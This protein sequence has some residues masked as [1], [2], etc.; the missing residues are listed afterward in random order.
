MVRNIKAGLAL[1]AVSCAVALSACNP[2]ANTQSGPATNGGTGGG[3][4]FSKTLS[5]TLK[6]SGFNPSDEVGKARGD[7]ATTQVAP[8]TVSMDTTNFD[9]Q[10]FAAQAAS[11]N[12]P[13]LIQ[14][15]R[16]TVDT[17]ADKGLIIPLDQCFSTWG[18]SP[19]E[20]YYP[21]AIKDVTYN[22]H[23]YGVP[24]FFQAS[25]IIGNKSVM[26]PAGVT[27]AD[28]DTSKP[29]QLIQVAKKMTKQ[30]GGKP[31]QLGFSPD[32]PGSSA[33][34]LA[35]FGGKPND[36]NGKPTLD[37][38]KNVEALTWMKSI[39]DAQGGYAKVKSFM[40]TFDTFGDKNEYVQN[41][42]GA[43]TWAQWYINVLSSTKDNVKLQATTIKDTSGSVI[44]FAGGTAFAIPKASKNPSAACAW[45]VKVTSLDA[46]M[47]AGS[48]RAATVAQKHSIM[49]GLFTGSPVADKAIRDKFV[50]PSGNADFDQLI[51]TSYDALQ[52][53]VSFGGSPVGQQISDAL[54]NAV[55]V[56]LTGEKTP[57]EA[58][59][60]AQDTAMRA[61]SQSNLGKNG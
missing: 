47:A 26:G 9:P 58:L 6:T 18:V 51:A 49:T 22:G 3:G 30:S 27:M 16:S 45:A 14:V 48:A 54:T 57:Q 20:Y 19:S 50:K 53:T 61:Y 11:G 35:V 13:D 37:D 31:T 10:K 44:G 8:V 33:L 12:V 7:Y 17:L 39:M 60:E 21:A 23:V 15:D 43:M 29:D 52:H 5:G 25:I 24:Q 42:A 40:D 59:K 32:L 2:A 56:T 1:V 55:T 28:L 41:Q 34:W 4:G 36:S 38:P 46:W